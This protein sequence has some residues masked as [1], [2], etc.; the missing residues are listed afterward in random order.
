MSTQSSR[1]PRDEALDQDPRTFLGDSSE[2][3]DVFDRRKVESTGETIFALRPK[4][5]SFLFFEMNSVK[6]AAS[7]L[8]YEPTEDKVEWVRNGVA[9]TLEWPS[10]RTEGS[11]CTCPNRGTQEE[12]KWPYNHAA[13]ATTL[14]WNWETKTG[15]VQVCDGPRIYYKILNE[16]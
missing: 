9:L 5:D 4:E 3:F 16:D 10:K 2:D 11:T 12:C 6:S 14:A 1:N 15:G 7:W 8:R 13:G